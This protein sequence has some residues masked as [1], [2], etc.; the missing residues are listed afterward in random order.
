MAS[1]EPSLIRSTKAFS[2]EIPE[3]STSAKAKRSDIVAGELGEIG[4]SDSHFEEQLAQNALK[5][6][7]DN[8]TIDT[9]QAFGAE[10]VKADVYA[11]AQEGASH[12]SMAGISPDHLHTP[13]GVGVATDSHKDH[14]VGVTDEHPEDRFIGIADEHS[15]DHLIGV[16]E[17]M[18]KIMW[19]ALAMMHQMSIRLPFQM[20]V[21]T[22]PMLRCQ[23]KRWKTTMPPLPK[24]KLKIICQRCRKTVSATPMHTCLT[25]P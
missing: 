18:I 23:L 3:G 13:T 2:V 5:Q 7:S 4:Q 15:E 11:H 24:T 22:I 14:L 6:T 10:Q 19:W 12:E 25:A 17:T 8:E 21:C 20:K 16:T 9:Q 1:K